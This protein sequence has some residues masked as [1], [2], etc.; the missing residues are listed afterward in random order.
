MAMRDLRIHARMY[1][2]NSYGMTSL[3]G[4][5]S[6]PF[7]I[8]ANRE[9][10]SRHRIGGCAKRAF[11]KENCCLEGSFRSEVRLENTIRFHLFVCL[12][13]EEDSAGGLMRVV[14]VSEREV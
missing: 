1:A 9:T 12:F 10:E 14:S 5:P 6:P 4:D 2:A 7:S 3:I 8:D 13:S 11:R